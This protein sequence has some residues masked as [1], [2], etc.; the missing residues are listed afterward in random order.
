[1]P[2][3]STALGVENLGLSPGRDY[4]LAETA[5][6]MAAAVSRLARD[7]DLV[8]SLGR[9]GAV[10]AQAFR[11][12]RIETSL[13][14]LYR[15][16]A[17]GAGGSARARSAAHA[18]AI[19]WEVPAAIAGLHAELSERDRRGASPATRAL[20]RAVRRLRRTRLALRAEALILRV[21]D[22]LRAPSGGRPL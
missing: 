15:E 4:L 9:A 12:S 14:P 5:G 6:E 21:L 19:T 3:V 16:I 18:R 13:E 2:V 20:R 17:S 8:T 11:W 1:M 7:P 10:R 22:R